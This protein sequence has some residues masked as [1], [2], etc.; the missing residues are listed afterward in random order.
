VADS[1]FGFVC[2]LVVDL[3]GK[4]FSPTSFVPGF[5]PA[6]LAVAGDS[7]FAASL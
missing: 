6:G 4:G 3:E 2:G 7:F 1:P 5:S